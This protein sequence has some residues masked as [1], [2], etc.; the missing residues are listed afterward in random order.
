[1]PFL[2]DYN[3]YTLK[4]LLF[5]FEFQ[6]M[7]LLQLLC[8]LCPNNEILTFTTTNILA[9]TTTAVTLW[10]FI[11]LSFAVAVRINC[12]TGISDLLEYF[13]FVIL[14]EWFRSLVEKRRQ[15]QTDG[16]GE[17]KKKTNDKSD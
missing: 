12:M 3:H 5:G 8:F 6:A 2:L 4:E 9:F 1:M 10:Y 15:H 11:N 13:V 17:Q 7:I 14:R 16:S